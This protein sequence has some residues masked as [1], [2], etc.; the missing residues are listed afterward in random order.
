MVHISPRQI[1]GKPGW[2][3]TSEIQLPRPRHEVFAFFA[4]AANLELLTPP[5]LRFRILTP[6]PITMHTGTLIDYRIRLYGVPIGWRTR[7]TAWEPGVRFID[8]QL[9]GPYRRWI[10][11]HEFEDAPGGTRMRDTVDYQVPGSTLINALFV[12]RA[13]RHIFE[14]RETAMRC[15]FPAAHPPGTRPQPTQRTAAHPV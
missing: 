4:D 10:H 6:L 1:D 8:E 13:V 2:R 7:I 3:L 11:Q 15:H 9:R 5:Y 14:F 12:R